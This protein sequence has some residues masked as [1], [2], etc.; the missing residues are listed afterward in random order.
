MN[1]GLKRK[2]EEVLVIK[3]EEEK[4]VA[5]VSVRN[6]NMENG[7]PESTSPDSNPAKWWRYFFN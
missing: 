4:K 2:G 3:E 5:G 7:D 6:S 1:L